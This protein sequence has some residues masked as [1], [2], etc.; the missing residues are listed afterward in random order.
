MNYLVG[1]DDTDSKF[2]MCT[3]YVAYQIILN[4]RNFSV[5][6]YPRLVRLNPNVP[7]KTRGNAAVC[8]DVTTEK[9]EACFEE[10]RNHVE[11][12][13][14]KEYGSNAGIV[15]VEKREQQNIFREIYKRAISGVINV[16]FVKNLLDREGITYFT[17]GNGMGIVG[18]SASIGFEPEKDYTFELIA[19]R[20]KEN[21]GK[22][23]YVEK[24][25]V[26]LMDKRTFPDTF[27]NYDYE[28]ER[29]LITP[30]GPDP[31]YFGIRGND[32]LTLLKALSFLRYGEAPDG[33]VIYLSNQHTD[34]HLEEEIKEK[35]YYSG[36]LEDKV[37]KIEIK[38]G[39]HVYIEFEKN[40]LRAA[41]YSPT[42][43]LTRVA[44]LL[45]PGDLIKV[46]GGI[47]RPSKKHKS[48]LNVEKIEVKQINRF[49][50]LNPLCPV[51]KKRM[52]S[53]GSNKGFECRKCKRKANEKIREEIE[54]KLVTGIYAASL[55]A[56]RH[57]TKP[58]IRYGNE[59]YAVEPVPI[60]NWFSRSFKGL[61]VR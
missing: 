40:K 19:Y 57:L 44:R 25:S 8:L 2:G 22:P 54:R 7:F 27:N 53:I 9:P 5:N 43:D 52:E 1:I 59:N 28:K 50:Y 45:L 24:D 17:I 56:H 31:V 3:T 6:P 55:R 11:R 21:W 38:Q 20:R 23:R 34:S 46:Y 14:Q 49:R 12:L 48:I 35:S 60:N 15:F 58:L 37:E 10:I 4:A 36:W 33:Y 18:A 51:C 16:K 30:H 26:I 47:R 32:P 41:I 61:I 39:G 13:S 42:G 29:V